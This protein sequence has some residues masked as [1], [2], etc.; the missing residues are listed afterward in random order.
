MSAKDLITR[1]PFRLVKLKLDY[2]SRTFGVSPCLATGTKCFNTYFTCKYLQAYDI[3]S[4]EYAFVSNYVKKDDLIKSAPELFSARPYITNVTVRPTE[5]SEEKTITSQAT[6]D[7][8][9][10]P[11]ADI[12][13]DPY[14]SSRGYTN[15]ESVKGTF[16]K[17]F[18]ARNPNW[19]KGTVEIY[20]CF[21]E[22]APGAYTLAFSGKI[23]D[24]TLNKGGVRIE[25]ADLL[26]SLNDIKYPINYGIK[27]TAAMPAIFTALN[28]SEMLSLEDAVKNDI[29]LRKDYPA[30][31]SS[32][33]V[34]LGSGSVEGYF[35]YRIIAYDSN[36][37]PFARAYTN[38]KN[39]DEEG[40]PTQV[41]SEVDL[42]WN[43]ASGASYY[44]VYRRA[45]YGAGTLRYGAEE[46]I[47][48]STGLSFTDD[49]QLERTTEASPQYAV[50]FFQLTADDF[51]QV[52]NWQS[53]ASAINISIDDASILTAVGQTSGYVKIDKEVIS[54]TG[55]SSNVLTGV[56]RGLF[57]TNTDGHELNSDVCIIIKRQAG[58][59]FQHLLD[60]LALGKIPS[61]NISPRFAAYRDA[62]TGIN[63]SC[64]EIL[65]DMKLADI[66]FDLVNAL[67]CYSWVNEAGQVDIKYK[68]DLTVAKNITDSDSVVKDSISVEIKDDERITRAILYWNRDVIDEALDEVQAYEMGMQ[69][70]DVDLEKIAYGNVEE[71]EIFSAWLNKAGNDLTAVNNYVYALV[72]KIQNRLKSAPVEVPLSVEIK[73]SDLLTG[74]VVQLTTD[75]LQ[76]IYGAPLTAL[77]RIIKRKPDGINTIKLNLRKTNG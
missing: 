3:T 66:Y 65:K 70:K 27:L 47:T 68:T 28:E 58:N 35:S 9:D 60:L 39:V 31:S 22:D 77:F 10:E 12:G 4:K 63:F 8:S 49:L 61:A 51:T 17:K 14:W 15:I 30:F 40:N 43:A 53:I 18:I 32:S 20:D 54:Y 59:P 5:L 55:I 19:I 2:C 37:N 33:Q 75:E 1:T 64:L 46:F 21:L 48:Q 67:D 41:G 52:S 57:D 71:K 38:V 69:V 29:C 24:I 11:D 44:R 73:D 62:W 50:R 76:D 45:S 26:E 36:G 74:H 72:E 23:K 7:L 25:C 6:I 34:G 42:S 16:W 13:I 56:N